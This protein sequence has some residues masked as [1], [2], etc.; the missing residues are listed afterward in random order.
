MG[1]ALTPAASSRFLEGSCLSFK[2]LYILLWAPYYI[3][4]LVRMLT[5][6]MLS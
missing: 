2:V 6:V 3:H 1:T 5:Y 4:I